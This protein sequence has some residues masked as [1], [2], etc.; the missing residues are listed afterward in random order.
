M[1]FH[2]IG[3]YLRELTK[4]ATMDYG[5]FRRIRRLD[6]GELPIVRSLEYGT[7]IETVF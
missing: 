4:C 7:E 2:L 1:V 3:N 6:E 5:Y